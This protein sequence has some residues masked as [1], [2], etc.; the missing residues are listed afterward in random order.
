MW[1]GSMAMVTLGRVVSK[2]MTR[3]S[4]NCFPNFDGA[5]FADVK[6]GGTAVPPNINPYKIEATDNSKLIRFASNVF[7]GRYS[8]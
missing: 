2:K 5:E 1:H 8:V 3:G 4:E 7:E 6:I